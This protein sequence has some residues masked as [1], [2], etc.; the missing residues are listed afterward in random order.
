MSMYIRAEIKSERS[1][2][3]VCSIHSTPTAHFT[4]RVESMYGKMKY[5]SRVG[6]RNVR[7]DDETNENDWSVRG[8]LSLKLTRNWTSEISFPQV[9][10]TVAFNFLKPCACSSVVDIESALLFERQSSWKW[11]INFEFLR[12]SLLIDECSIGFV[13]QFHIISSFF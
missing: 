11:K 2:S 12:K 7:A 4:H 10:F 3:V 5:L 9:Y 13:S 6:S 1:A 8:K